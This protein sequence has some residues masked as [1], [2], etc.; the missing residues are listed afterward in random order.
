MS[1]GRWKAVAEELN[2]FTLSHRAP[3]QCRDSFRVIA[4]VL[5]AALPWAEV[6]HVG[7]TAVPECLTKG[8]L[9]VL[10]RVERPDFQR[11]GRILDE[12]LVCSTRNARTD[13]YAEY[14]YAADTVSASVQ[15]VVAGGSLDDH[16]HRLKAILTSDPAARE[17]YNSLKLRHDG[18]DMDAYRRAKK[19]LIDSLLVLDAASRDDSDGASLRPGIRE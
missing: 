17:A 11:S 9:D 5:S 7:S 19:R 3:S 4:G 8:D 1:A 10:V 12:L 15:L 13:E 16:F 18:R 14:D 6:E 2:V